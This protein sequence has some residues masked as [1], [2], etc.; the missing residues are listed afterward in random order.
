MLLIHFQIIPVRCAMGNEKS[1]AG[2]DDEYSESA[3]N[4]EKEREFE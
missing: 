3:N 2:D 1:K 4:I